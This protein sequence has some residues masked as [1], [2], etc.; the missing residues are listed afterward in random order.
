MAACSASIVGL[1]DV[2]VRG[3]PGGPPA[4]HRPRPGDAGCAQCEETTARLVRSHGPYLKRSVAHCRR[5]TG[6]RRPRRR[7]PRP[8]RRRSCK[9]LALERAVR[10]DV[11]RAA[12]PAK[13]SAGIGQ[14]GRGHEPR[15]DVHRDLAQ[16]VEHALHLRPDDRHLVEELL[17]ARVVARGLQGHDLA[18]Q[19]LDARLDPVGIHR[20]RA[21]RADLERARIEEGIEL[22]RDARGRGPRSGRSGWSGSRRPGTSC[23]SAA[24][25]PCRS[26]PCRSGTAAPTGRRCRPSPPRA[27]CR[28]PSSPG[29]RWWRGRPP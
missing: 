15:G 2:E 13:P 3:G 25:W 28:A 5:P 9:Q 14:L 7:S 20:E 4:Q 8:P 18:G 17:G 1:L 12:V 29:A 10:L 21:V 16:T 27:R 22:E 11:T 19:G 24:P 6:E 26:R 23:T